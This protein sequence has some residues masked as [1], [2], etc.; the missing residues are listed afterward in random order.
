M[1]KPTKTKAYS[2]KSTRETYGGTGYTTNKAFKATKS[3]KLISE[4][5]Q[6]FPTLSGKASTFE[7]ATTA[8]DTTGCSKGKKSF[9]A[10]KTTYNP[11]DTDL[12]TGEQLGI[13]TERFDVPRNKVKKTIKEMKSNTGMLQ[14]EKKA[15]TVKKPATST[16]TMV[17]RYGNKT[18]K[19]FKPVAVN[20][21]EAFRKG[22]KIIK[23]F[24]KPVSEGEFKN[25]GKKLHLGFKEAQAK[26]AKKQGISMESAGAILASSARK[27]SPAAVK[28]N[29]ALLN[30]KRGKVKKYQDGGKTSQPPKNVLRTGYKRKLTPAEAREYA[31][32]NPNRDTSNYLLNQLKKVK[33][34]SGIKMSPA[35]IK[36]RKGGKKC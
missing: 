22:G 29:P 14:K 36:M 21:S 25:G 10:K 32:K 5:K 7:Y 19:A 8:L 35:K 23:N 31:K 4:R 28:K 3:G 15:K 18:T 12:L 24:S 16:K 11:F 17:D 26:I 27:A 1:K 33:P 13:K 34:N 9:P 2:S 30:V 6:E 20:K